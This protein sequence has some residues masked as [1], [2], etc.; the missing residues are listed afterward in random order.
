MLMDCKRCGHIWIAK[1]EKPIQCPKCKQ[2][3]YD[4][5]RSWTQINEI[6]KVTGVNEYEEIPKI[7]TDDKPVEEKVD[8]EKVVDKK[9]V[10]WD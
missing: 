3:Y 5:A 10:R 8:T 7:I 1:V 4:R 9:I 2:T 6:K